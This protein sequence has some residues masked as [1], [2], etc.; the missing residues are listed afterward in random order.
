[1]DWCHAIQRKSAFIFK[2][3][4]QSILCNKLRFNSYPS[5]YPC[6]NWNKTSWTTI[7]SDLKKKQFLHVKTNHFTL[8][9]TNDKRK[10]GKIE[11]VVISAVCRKRGAALYWEARAMCCNESRKT[12][13]I[14]SV[15]LS[16]NKN[17]VRKQEESFPVHYPCT[18]RSFIH[19]SK[20]PDFS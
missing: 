19:S 4:R 11:H 7:K 20:I 12:G 18:T 10:T 3:I 2:I 17:I 1:M 16:P 14:I 13:L 15:C 5:I 8:K 9:T 6:T